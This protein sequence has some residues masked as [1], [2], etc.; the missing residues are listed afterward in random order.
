M[1]FLNLISL[2]GLFI[3]GGVV[4]GIGGLRRPVQSRTLLGSALMMV[5]LGGLIFLVPSIRLVL[6]RLDNLVVN[7]LGATRL[8]AEFLFGPLAL[9]PGPD[10]LAYC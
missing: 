10:N 5:L 9:N 4:W 3:L 2:V 1:D 6:L 7:I 8:G